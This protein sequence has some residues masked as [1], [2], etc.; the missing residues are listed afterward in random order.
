M[1]IF[2][3]A[4]RQCARV[5]GLTALA[6]LTAFLLYAPPTL[7]TDSDA[8]VPNDVGVGFL[9]HGQEY[10]KSETVAV[11]TDLTGR[12]DS[13]AVEEWI[14]NPEELADITDSSS[15]QNIV[16]K[17][18]EV[19]FKRDGDSL[20]WNTKGKDVV[21]TG[22]SNRE[23]PFEISYSYWLDGVE[24]DP[25]TLKDAT[26]KLAVHISYKNL[27]QGSVFT[28][29]GVQYS[30]QDPFVMASVISFDAEHARNVEVD[31]GSVIDQQGTLMVIGLAM[32]GLEETLQ[33]EDLVDL[34][35]DVTIS[36]DVKGFDMPDITTVVT[37]QALSMVDSETTE[38]VQNQLDDAIGQLG[39]IGD[40]VGQ[41]SKGNSK[42]GEATGAISEGSAAMAENLPNATD[43]LQKL[44]ELATMAHTALREAET[45]QADIAV[46]LQKSAEAQAA[47]AGSLKLAATS[48]QEAA[49]ANKQVATSHELAVQQQ[50]QAVE[51][52]EQAIE[53]QGAATSSLQAA[54]QSQQDALDLLP[55]S[56]TID[57]G[58]LAE[59]Q[60]ALDSLS[61]LD[62][63]KMGDT[64]K[65]AI[66]SAITSLEQSIAQTQASIEA[67][68]PSATTIGQAREKLIES[69]EQLANCAEQLQ[70]SSDT[71]GESADSLAT[72]SESLEA[73]VQNLAESDTSLGDATT[74]IGD[75]GKSLELSLKSLA[76]NEEPAKTSAQNLGIATKQT[77]MLATGLGGAAEGFTQVQQGVAGLSAGLAQV[78]DANKKLGTAAKKMSKG[79]KEAIGTVQSSIDEKVELV[80]A[81]HDYVDSQPAFGGNDPDTRA[82]TMY[83][84]HAKSELTPLR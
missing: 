81:L 79:V 38:D 53:S 52:Q 68:T 25:G 37:S 39:A 6:A 48:A 30:I 45:N 59:Q 4:S 8:P 36:A 47:A 76:N 57:D 14:K 60:A 26:G 49:K 22:T 55:E 28:P 20:V 19:T 67:S 34:P 77:E 54:T 80:N 41:L 72:S 21:Y 12:I 18:D 56:A 3:N 29:S 69:Q 84:V 23:L 35:V 15:L 11:K 51:S 7:A 61:A 2:P 33:V 1:A 58:I 27:T 40:A 64:E 31:N 70:A 16:A 13:L 78:S 50:Q 83:V 46:N 10:G 43:G 71:L 5:F 63:S 74:Q 75:S 44:A 82:S 42:L 24:V 66:E 65:A 32:P 9:P 62:T 17:D 73:A